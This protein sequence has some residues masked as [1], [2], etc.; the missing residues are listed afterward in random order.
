MPTRRDSAPPL[1]TERGDIHFVFRPKVETDDPAGFADVERFYLVLH[2]TRPPLWRVI[3]IGRKRLPRIDAHERNWGFVD[4]VTR[5]VDEVRRAFAPATYQTKTR[6]E[7]HLPPARPAGA[8]V[9]ALVRRGRQL[10]LVYR[11]ALP[12]RPG[13]VQAALGIERQGNFVLSVKNPEKPAP[14]GVGLGAEQKPKLPPR[15]QEEFRDRRFETEAPDPLNFPGAEIILI[16]ARHGT[17]IGGEE[18]APPAH[19][20]KTAAADLLALLPEAREGAPVKPLL[21]GEWG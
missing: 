8:G 20:E 9:Y 10:H 1:V 16:G 15:V 3:V 19:G 11:R 2:P 5:K 12:E 13:P 18:T 7:R 6:G 4:L 17:R 14:P 21:K